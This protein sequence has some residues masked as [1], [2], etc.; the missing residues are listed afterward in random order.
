VRKNLRRINSLFEF[1]YTPIFV[2]FVRQRLQV[3]TTISLQCIKLTKP[4]FFTDVTCAFLQINGGLWMKAIW[5]III[6]SPRR[7]RRV[8]FI[9][10][11]DL[12]LKLFLCPRAMVTT[13]YHTAAHTSAAT[14]LWWWRTA[15]WIRQL[16]DPTTIAPHY[17]LDKNKEINPAYISN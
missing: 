12:F 1:S 16:Q 7:T 3:I 6:I 15:N 10:W 4:V 8:S 13:S 14:S 2:S 17:G 11:I 9:H 5:Y